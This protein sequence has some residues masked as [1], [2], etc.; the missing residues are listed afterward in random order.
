ML[1]ASY[2]L[3]QEFYLDLS[4]ARVAIETLLAHQCATVTTTAWPLPKLYENLPSL[5]SPT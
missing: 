4:V 2:M 5:N 3:M 1:S